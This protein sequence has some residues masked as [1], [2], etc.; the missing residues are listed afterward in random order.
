MCGV[1]SQNPI[2]DCSSSV[3]P[4]LKGKNKEMSSC[5][6]N[7]FPEDDQ[8]E[9]HESANLGNVRISCTKTYYYAKERK[10]THRVWNSK[11]SL[12][13]IH[14]SVLHSVTTASNRSDGTK[15]ASFSR[16][17]NKALCSE[18]G[19][20]SVEQQHAVQTTR[21]TLRFAIFMIPNCWLYKRTGQ[22]KYD[23]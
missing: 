7:N 15:F 1:N 10:R 21:Q 20:I 16:P 3:C 5:I 11:A 22:R 19:E 14:G 6:T 9:A 17:D 2:Q 8:K 4:Q 12:Q 13:T 18:R 23:E